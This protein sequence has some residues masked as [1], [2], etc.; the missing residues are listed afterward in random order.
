MSVRVL[1]PF[2]VVGAWCATFLLILPGFAAEPQ[3]SLAAEPQ[4]AVVESLLQRGE[5][6]ELERRWGEALTLYEDALRQHPAAESLER[7]LWV[8]KV[9]YDLE[10]RH[11]DP[12]FEHSLAA[13]ALRDSLAMYAEVLLMI[14]THH[15]DRPDWKAL[16]ERGRAGLEIALADTLF[17]EKHFQDPP[18]E[19]IESFREA[20]RERL[21]RLPLGTRLEAR[22]AVAA[23]ADLAQ[24]QLGLPGTAVVLEFTCGATNSLD[25]YSSFLT[26]DQLSEVYS[27]IEGNFVGLGVELRSEDGELYIVRVIPGSPA[28]RGGI[29]AGDSI[30]EVD[31][32]RTADINSDE[33]ANLLQGPEGSN[34]QVTAVT[35]G[36]APRQ[37]RLRREQV[38][39]PSVDDVKIVDA[40]SGVGYMKLTCFQK[41]TSRDVDAALW[42]LHRSGM[43]SL[44][45]DL[46]G[47][48][49]GLLTSSVEVADKFVEQGVI[50]TTRGRN[51]EEDYTYSARKAGTWRVPLVVLIDG[52][53]AS[54]SEIF[55][56]AIRDHRRGTIVGTRSYGK[57]S[58]QGIFS[59]NSTKA[60][61]RLT[62]AKFYSP[63][64]KPFSK[65]G[66]SPD[67]EVRQAARPIEG[68]VVSLPPAEGDLALED[69][70]QVARR[71]FDRR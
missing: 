38:D 4:T 8:S 1:R 35:P 47:N 28:D 25:D 32:Q 14:Q 16:V 53:S 40:K 41:T 60:G 61:L 68:E 19:K 33:A 9:H 50:V 42:K 66:V 26:G 29:R 63:L 11:H 18:Y 17:L 64:G 71:Q 20:L 39:V 22:D 45:M 34:V 67:R 59:L 49:G 30:V 31:G 21:A 52:D 65:I 12:S 56:G 43:R 54:A 37:L 70:V 6:L 48:P 13:L 46:R 3:T 7:H 15:V 58:V 24:K 10:R 69:A 55:A 23:A 5:Q 27:Q 2:V 51:A 36:G 62:T 44:I 57:G